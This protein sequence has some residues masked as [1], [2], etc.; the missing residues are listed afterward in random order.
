MHDRGWDRALLAGVLYFL[1]AT[2]T[3]TLTANGTGIAV[4]WPANAALLALL[5]VDDKPRWT[6]VLVAGL[7]A[8]LAANLVTRGVFLGGLLYG[9]MNLLEVAL[10]AIALRSKLGIA[11]LIGQPRA[12]GTFM[13]WAGLI[14]PA[15]SAAGG[16]ITAALVFEQSFSDA[17]M[18]WYLADALGLLIFTPAIVAVLRG[19]L[20]RCF[21]AASLKRS[22]EF[23]VLQSLVVLSA[24]AV[25]FAGHKPLLFVLF[26]FVMLVSF[27][28]GRLGTKLSVLLIALIGASATLTGHGPIVMF[29]NAQDQQVLYLQFFLAV[30]LFTCLPVTAGLGARNALASDLVEEQRALL[31]RTQELARKAATDPLTG[32]FN[33]AGFLKAADLAMKNPANRPMWLIAIDVDHFKQINDNFGHQAG[34]EALIWIASVLRA[35]LRHDDV[36]A[37]IGGDEFLAMLPA[38]SEQE[39]RNICTRL[40]TSVSTSPRLLQGKLMPLSISCG[41]APA[42]PDMAIEA[43]MQAADRALYEAKALG[44]NRSLLA[45]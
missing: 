23:A 1:L 6:S 12:L 35:T 39:V 9:A 28:S 29:A 24:A 4:F 26:P 31:E 17:A 40:V 15:A 30:L 44:R 7:I 8:N 10:A 27:R 37:R 19:E 34:D 18:T 25:F 14:A 21:A 38:R 2:A 20:I 41:G 22:L 45:A 33:R 43:L 42:R 11:S 32:V 36:L 5:L 3:I 13:L 16:G